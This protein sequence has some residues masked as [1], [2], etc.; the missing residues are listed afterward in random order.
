M[1]SFQSKNINKGKSPTATMNAPAVNGNSFESGDSIPSFVS[2]E[3]LK[4]DQ[5]NDKTQVQDQSEFL[6]KVHV[7]NCC[8]YDRIMKKIT[9]IFYQTLFTIYQCFNISKR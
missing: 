5:N 2:L 4:E 6:E 8:L 3:A 7:K 9:Q 1:K